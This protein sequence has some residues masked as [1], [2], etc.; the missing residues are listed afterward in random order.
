[1]VS[2]G[3]A[4]GFAIYF[5]HA[6]YDHYNNVPIIVVINPTPMPIDNV[7]FPA[8]TICSMNEA[9][10]TE[11]KIIL[12]NGYN[13]SK[14]VFILALTLKNHIILAAQ[15]YQLQCNFVTSTNYLF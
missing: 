4:L 3:V 12:H 10:L 2:F 9:R 5:I 15:L 8:L 6:I 11:A 14:F 7:P 13:Q 1:M